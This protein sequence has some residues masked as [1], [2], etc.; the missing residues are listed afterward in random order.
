MQ[1]FRGMLLWPGSWHCR[2]ELLSCRPEGNSAT[3][4]FFKGWMA[5]CAF[6]FWQSRSNVM[7]RSTSSGFGVHTSS[8]ACFSKASCDGFLG[9]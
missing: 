1:V 3:R 5:L 8:L 2:F 6:G 7:T 4:C 9:V